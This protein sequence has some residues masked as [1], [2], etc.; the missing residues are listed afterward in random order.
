MQW[1][2][3]AVPDDNAGKDKPTVVVYPH[4]ASIGMH[5]DYVDCV[6]FWGDLVLSKASTGNNINVTRGEI[7]LWKIDGFYS[8]DGDPPE[9]P[10][11]GYGR[12]TRS[13]FGGDFQRLYTFDMTNIEP[14]YM[15]FGLFKEPGYRPIL[16]MGNIKARFSFWDLQRFEERRTTS[17]KAVTVIDD[18]QRIKDLVEEA[19]SKKISAGQASANGTRASSTT[20][21]SDASLRVPAA[22]FESNK[23]KRSLTEKVLINNTTRANS[24]AS[25]S[26]RASSRADKQLGV[27][28]RTKQPIQSTKV[29]TISKVPLAFRSSHLHVPGPA[30]TTHAATDSA[31]TEPEKPPRST[32]NYIRHAAHKTT[33]VACPI[34][35]ACRAVDWSLDGRWCVA[36]G[37]HGMIAIFGRWMDK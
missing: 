10:M 22:N 8:S 33:V 24:I 32:R 11:P 21:D 1:S 19:K 26:T 25:D 17:K 2:V 9:P 4:F 37:D 18:K 6:R 27:C 12:A 31:T 16:V 15:R 20:T 29:L 7:M 28:D 36:V 23:R 5:S 35:F 34:D 13:A 14:F 30:G 3:P